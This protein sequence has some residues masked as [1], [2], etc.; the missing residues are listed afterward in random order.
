MRA[1]ELIVIPRRRHSADTP[2]VE[3]SI[4]T[5]AGFLIGF[6]VESHPSELQVRVYLGV[7]ELVYWRAR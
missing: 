4:F 6:D 5:V 7:L 3:L 2:G 1:R